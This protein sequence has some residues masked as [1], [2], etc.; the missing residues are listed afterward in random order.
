MC[1]YYRQH[2]HNAYCGYTHNSNQVSSNKQ[3]INTSRQRS[4]SSDSN[5]A[6]GCVIGPALIAGAPKVVCSETMDCLPGMINQGFWLEGFK[7]NCDECN[8]NLVNYKQISEN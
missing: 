8:N 1:C 3:L 2:Y 7:R 4:D 5:N 6:I